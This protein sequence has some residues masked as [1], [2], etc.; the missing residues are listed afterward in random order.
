MSDILPSMGDVIIGL[1]N[2]LRRMEGDVP[3]LAGTHNL[4]MGKNNPDNAYWAKFNVSL[5]TYDVPNNITKVIG[6]GYVP[7][8][9]SFLPATSPP[10]C[11][12]KVAM[13]E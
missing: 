7:S 13:N 1:A 11:R 4:N 3:E 9:T 6:G 8:P 2:H 10:T 12:S 5:N